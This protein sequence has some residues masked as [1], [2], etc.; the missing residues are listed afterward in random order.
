MRRPSRTSLAA[1]LL[2]LL[3]ALLPTPVTPAAAQ[4][5]TTQP[6][7]GM[8]RLR[9]QTTW[10]T[11]EQP[12][13]LELAVLA[14]ADLE[15]AVDLFAKIGNRSTF[16]GTVERGVSGRPITEVPPVRVAELPTDET[17]DR[18]LTFTPPTRADGVYPMRVQLRATG[19]GT[20][21]DSFVTYL[22]QVPAVLEGEPLSV[23][24]VVPVHAPPAV[25][26]DG[27]VAI[28]DERAEEL[29]DLA[30]TLEEHAE[31]GLTLA[32]TPETVEALATSPRAQDR[33]TMATLAGALGNRQLLGGPW[34][35]TDLTAILGGGLED[36]S[37]GLLTR[38][39]QALRTQFS[40]AEPV[41]STRLVDEPLTVEGLAF[42]QAQQ[43]A[44]RLVVPETFLEPVRQN[45]TLVEQFTI[46]GR[47]PTTGIAAVGVDTALAANFEAADPVLGAHRLLADLAV[48][49]NDDPDFARRGVVITP[50]RTWVPNSELLDA[51]LAGLS[52]SPVLRGVGLD[53]FFTDV[54]VATTGS[55]SRAAPLVRRVAVDPATAPETIT[56]PSASIRTARRSIERFA[57]AVDTTDPLGAAVLDRLDRTLLAATSSDLR[58]RDR[59]RY[60]AGVDDQLDDQLAAIDM[61]ENRSI[62]LT[63]R[64]GEIPVTVRSNLGY[65]VRAVLRVFSDDRLDFP[66]GDRH[67]LDLPIRR[68]ATSQFTV[69]AQSSG[70]FPVRVELQS[71]DGALVLAESRFTVRSTA[72][73]GVGTAL[74]IGA[75]LFL[76]VW[77]ANHL[78][79]R[80]SRRLVPT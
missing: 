33:G 57:S 13:T 20:V 15:V 68:N 38:G 60:V 42:L 80:R 71:P 69:R 32:P 25:Q 77:W 3:A 46:A 28:D 78:R 10:W 47:T 50:P 55:G 40:G 65:R 56:L 11:P 66:A 61:P 22:V 79:G 53:R 30:S 62:T 5:T 21:I 51:L 70:S 23:G 63:A 37:A 34:V 1:V 36:E 43:Q 19:G 24:L 73:S 4:T 7:S 76:L 58:S 64:D 35:P 31:V 44:T 17:G 75:G 72:I 27:D 67:S 41:T 74:S 54:D 9:G 49:Y 16:A 18:I 26:P 48:I 29:A 6:S 39:T 59:A 14:T 45:K 52:T 8:L 2:A 12:V